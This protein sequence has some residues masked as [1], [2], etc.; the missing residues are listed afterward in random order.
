LRY[1]KDCRFWD[2]NSCFVEQ[3]IVLGY[4]AASLGIHT[5][6]GW[7]DLHTVSSPRRMES[8]LVANTSPNE[9]REMEGPLT[10]CAAQPNVGFLDL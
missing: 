9:M 3:S 10:V 7:N 6:K 4:D 8:F 1:V 2:L 5:V